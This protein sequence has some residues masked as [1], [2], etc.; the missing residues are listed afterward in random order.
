MF[1]FVC[2]CM[3]LAAVFIRQTSLAAV[4]VLRVSSVALLVSLI[5][6][7]SVKGDLIV[8]GETKQPQV[9]WNFFF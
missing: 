4:L 7:D 9:E 5:H 6:L 1:V 2:V 3:F 8:Q